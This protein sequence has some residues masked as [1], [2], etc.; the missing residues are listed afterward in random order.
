MFDMAVLDH[1]RP[2]LDSDPGGA[3][4]GADALDSRASGERLAVLA[5]QS[6]SPRVVAALAGLD[7]A[8]L[9]DDQRLSHVVALKRCSAWLE[10][11]Q[12]RSLA[13]I[14]GTC[15]GGDPDPFRRSLSELE[16][17]QWT[18]EEVG[19]ALRLSPASTH[20][21]LSLA[22]ALCG[23]PGPPEPTADADDRDSGQPSGQPWR[24]RL[25][26]TYVALAEGS[27]TVAHARA[28]VELTEPLDPAGCATVEAAVL[29]EA[30]R[31][32]VAQLAKRLRRAVIEAEPSAAA[33]RHTRARLERRTWVRPVEDGM[34][35]LYAL[36]PAEDA[37]TAHA[38]LDA[39]AELTREQ[40]RRQA[41]AA[42]LDWASV[43]PGLGALRADALTDVLRG[44][45]ADPRLPLHQGRRP[46]VQVTI[47]LATLMG[48]AERPG[49]LVGYGPIPAPFARAI[50]ADG[51]WRRLVTDPVTGYLMDFGRSTYEPPAALRDYVLARDVT[52][53]FP[54]DPRPADRCDLD[55]GI[56][57]QVGGSTSAANLGAL[58]RHPHNG[59]TLGLWLLRR[60]PDETVLW[61]SPLGRHYTVTPHAYD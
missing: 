47:D 18:R 20:H 59:K 46:H 35:M 53:R 37:R 25:P 19:A 9:D 4:L 12:L 27:I 41:R 16:A 44:V 11:L 28:V 50:A 49:E 2:A 32:S 40:L 48:L 14:G 6:P 38:A 34:A 56:S 45:L 39:R 33:E 60:F 21:R 57:W 61:T 31:Q 23:G 7:P 42:G 54:F 8:D 24:P 13:L 3:A 43:N 29:P 1:P 30:H 10:A 58:S 36:L 17:A 55:H 22:R 51:S 52:S 15:P 26:D 5:A